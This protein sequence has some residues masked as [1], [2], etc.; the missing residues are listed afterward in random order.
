MNNQIKA[1]YLKR[2]ICISI[3][4]PIL[5]SIIFWA[6]VIPLEIYYT[7]LNI[8]IDK[9]VIYSRQ[10]YLKTISF[11]IY[12]IWF[13]IVD[14]FFS[15]LLFII[16]FNRNYWTPK[17]VHVDNKFP[18]K[19]NKFEKF[20]QKYIL[21]NKKGEPKSYSNFSA[22][23]LKK[24]KLTII[25]TPYISL[26]LFCAFP[27]AS[28]VIFC[29]NYDNFPFTLSVINY[30]FY[31]IWALISFALHWV[32]Y[33]MLFYYIVKFNKINIQDFNSKALNNYVKNRTLYPFPLLK[34]KYLVMQENDKTIPELDF[35][36]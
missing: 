17:W 12:D 25:L 24:L 33:K 3:L 22:K 19:L 13:I 11:I 28:C 1:K 30:I 8:T 27:I 15:L 16:I 4:I 31:F 21:V 32:M 7:N 10:Q 20:I 18:E 2:N 29:V 34:R 23:K 5:L 9:D 6:V 35:N 26:F 36:I 14:V